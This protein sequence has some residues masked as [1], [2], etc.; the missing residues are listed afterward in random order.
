MP[1]RPEPEE[2]LAARQFVAAMAALLLA[3]LAA[4]LWLAWQFEGFLTGDDLEIVQTAAK[5]ALGVRYDPWVLRCL[6]HPVA[7]VAPVLKLGAWLGARDPRVITWLAAI[8]TALFST[9]GIWL[10]AALAR[11]LG[12]TRRAS[13]AAAF[14]SAFAWLPLAYGSSPFPRPISTAMLLAAFVLVATPTRALWPALAAGLLAGAAFAVRWSEGVVLIPLLAFPLLLSSSASP[15]S[16]SAGRT[17]E[18]RGRGAEGIRTSAAIAFGFVLGTLLFAG[19]TDWLTWGVPLKSLA[20]YFRIMFLERPPMDDQPPWDYVH[21]ALKWAG[22]ILLLLLIPAWKERRVRPAIAVFLSIV[23][24]LS[25]FSHK[26]WRYLQAAIPFLA[27][28]AAAGWERLWARTGY[29][30]ALAGAALVLSVPYGIE[31][32]VSLLSNRSGSELDA[33]RFINGLTPRPRTLAFVQQWAYGEHLYLGNDVEIRE[34]ELSRPIRARAIADAAAGA[35]VAA[36][37]SLYFDDGGRREF[38]KLGFRQIARFHRLKSY[39]CLVF[40]RGP[41]AAAAPPRDPR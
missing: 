25:F 26:E 9:A 34:I 8:P 11:R 12:S 36:V 38:E 32:T 30:R 31:R 18:P 27:I 1:E 2:P 20:E 17:E 37:Y 16:S 4:K 21:D 33:A 6:F 13:A 29:R 5:Y 22:P 40:G 23:V 3:T 14:F 24:L 41:Y 28:A 35:D 39:E 7:L 15:L 10:T 19:V